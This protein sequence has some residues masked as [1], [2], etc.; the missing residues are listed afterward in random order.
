MVLLYGPQQL[1]RLWSHTPDMAMVSDIPHIQLSMIRVS[2][3]ADVLRIARILQACCYLTIKRP[4]HRHAAGEHCLRRD[5][6][7]SPQQRI[8]GKSKYPIFEV[9]GSK[10]HT[11]NGIWDQR[12]QIFGT[13]TLWERLLVFLAHG[14]K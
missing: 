12:P 14:K 1:P 10:N 11:L 7:R 13:W 5:I 6:V 3:S 9:S 4:S 8:P 2:L